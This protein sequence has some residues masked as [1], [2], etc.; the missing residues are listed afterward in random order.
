MISLQQKAGRSLI[1]RKHHSTTLSS[2]T[3]TYRRCRTD[4][5]SSFSCKSNF[6][7]NT[8]NAI[9]NDDEFNNTIPTPLQEEIKLSYGKSDAA[10]TLPSNNLLMT[11]Q[12]SSSPSHQQYRSS[13]T[14]TAYIPDAFQSFTIWGGS[15]ILLKSIHSAN[16]PYWA[17]FSVTNVIVRSSLIPLVLQ[18]AHTATKI[19]KVAPEIQFLASN[20]T[21]DLKKMKSEGRSVG[22]QAF[23]M[24]TTW[25]TMRAIYKYHKVNPLAIFKSPLMQIP[26]FWY[27][28]IDI[29]KIINGA[30]PELAQQ[31]TESGFLWITDL[32]EPDPWYGLPIVS[33]MLLYLN[34][35]WAVGRKTLSGETASK[36]NIAKYMKDFFQSLAV[37]MPCFMSQSPAGV[38]VYLAT[39]FIFTLFQG[40]ALRNDSVR[41]IVGLPVMNAPMPESILARGFIDLKTKEKEARDARGET[42]EVFGKH[43]ILM[44][45]YEGS[46][47]CTYRASTIDVGDYIGRSVPDVVESPSELMM[48]EQQQ[49]IPSMTVLGGG[50]EMGQMVGPWDPQYLLDNALAKKKKETSPETSSPTK[51]QQPEEEQKYMV[52]TAEEIMEA[53]NRGELPKPPVIMAPKEKKTA[54]DTPL[55]VKKIATKRRG[56]GGKKRGTKKGG[57]KK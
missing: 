32:T 41:E 38:Q 56:V 2:L 31:L 21:N 7:T 13:S 14:L 27:F 26:V 23:V 55:N 4:T 17:C 37:F 28:S 49:V 11:R 53:A 33:G 48:E 51:Q 43:G 15:G 29:R 12:L 52:Q 46:L 22:E 25:R 16:L 40:M 34:V 47:P 30:D 9:Q 42:E 19:A 36:S 5:L 6:S 50:G 18:G 57:R 8:S 35:E 54:E 44:P 1:I 3:T 20:F 45:G 10:L 24:K 39:S